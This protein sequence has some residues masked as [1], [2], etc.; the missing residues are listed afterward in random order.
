ME[1]LVG[2]IRALAG[3]VGAEKERVMYEPEKVTVYF[4][5]PDKPSTETVTEEG[6]FQ[7][8]RYELIFK[9]VILGSDAKERDIKHYVY[10]TPL[11]SWGEEAPGGQEVVDSNPDITE[12][13]LTPEEA[14]REITWRGKHILR[15]PEIY[16]AGLEGIY[17][18]THK[19]APGKEYTYDKF[20]KKFRQSDFYKVVSKS[21]KLENP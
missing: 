4:S 3:R 1:S 7:W 6:N 15:G 5:A 11:Y 10:K 9:R 18:N 13:D 20:N 16:P 14:K 19:S 17:I 12:V 2:F 8:T 21:K